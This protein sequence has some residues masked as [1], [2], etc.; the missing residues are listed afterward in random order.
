MRRTKI[1][2]VCL[3]LLA[4][5]AAP[6]VAFADAVDLEQRVMQMEKELQELKALLKQEGQQR[7]TEV[8][9]I[10]TQVAEV[11]KTAPKAN[12][13]LGD[14]TTLTYGG[15]IKVNGLYSDYDD[16]PRP[17]NIGDE[18]LVP[19]TIP[20]GGVGEGA[21][22]DS[23]VKTSRFFFKTSTQ[24]SAGLLNSHFEMDLLSGGGDERVSNS[25]NSRIRHAYFDW[26]YSSDASLLVG[27][28]WS[29]FFNV[30]ALPESVEFIGPTSGT[31]FNRQTQLRWTKSLGSGSFMLAA[32]NP[33]TSLTDAGSGIAASNYDDNSVPDIV[34]RFNGKAGNHA[35]TI[36]AL[37]REIAYD[38][39][40]LDESDFGFALNL[41]GKFSLGNGDDIRYSFSHGN[42][43]RYIALN[44]FRDGGIDAAG[45]LELTDVTGGYVAYRH[46]WND[47]L[48]S[49][50][51]YALATADLAP[52]IA[53][54]NTERVDNFN[55]NLMYSPTPK[56]TFGGA[57]IKASRELENGAKGELN[58][59]QVTAKFAF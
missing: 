35:Y 42:L 22:F 15:F 56:L 59:L 25:T 41:S 10:N 54:S 4:A 18:I 58:R 5:T 1:A 26:K 12:L 6:G 27:Q 13:K 38:D 49:T 14:N 11:A 51:Q 16:G 32:E 33:S 37:G 55:V 8:A 21:Q 9:A 20:V 46:N 28:T 3:S 30:G 45:N 36:A 50:I 53:S 43:G 48:R 44:A 19:S 34:A 57:L 40:L 24:T 23:D 39:G 47:K 31:I 7:E 29:T 17:G 2:C 52:G